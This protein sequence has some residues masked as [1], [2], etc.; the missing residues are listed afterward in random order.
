MEVLGRA[1]RGGGSA[2]DRLSDLPDCLLHA[3]LSRLKARQVVRTCV[4]S[5]RWQHLWLTSP[6]LDVDVGEFRE[7]RPHAT[8]SLHGLDP[9]W[10]L[11]P[12]EHANDGEEPYELP[13]FEDFVDSLLVHR[14]RTAGALPLE[15]LRLR[16]PPWWLIVPALPWMYHDGTFAA[17]NKH[18]RWVR[19]GL[20]CSPATLDVCG[21]VKLPPLSASTTRRL[22]SLRLDQVILH[23]DFAEHLASGLPVLEDLRITG[24]ILS[25]LP[26]IASGTL[27]SLVVESSTLHSG[28]LTFTIAAPRL[29]SLHLAVNFQHLVSFAVVVQEAPCLVQ[30]SVRLVGTPEPR[31]DLLRALCKFIDSLSHVCALKL[32]GFRDMTV[33]EQQHQPLPLGAQFLPDQ[34]GLLNP[35]VP[36]IPPLGLFYQ[37]QTDLPPL[38]TDKFPRPML[39]AMLDE[40][41]HGLPVFS[42]MRT[43]VLED[44]EMGDHAQTLWRFLHNAPALEKLTLNN[45]QCHEFPNSSMLEL[46]TVS[47]T[48]NLKSVGIIEG[49]RDGTDPEQRDES[50]TSMM[51]GKLPATTKIQVTK[52]GGRN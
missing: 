50:L 23:R 22:T 16:L 4:L 11:T 5:R 2:D 52:F 34:P 10:L 19:R 3:I 41:H 7:L 37:F 14:I 43:L 17:S 48:P 38:A 28:S 24:T 21:S 49:D 39:Q 27:K 47:L 30:A 12:A 15:T 45:C 46:P 32:H 6:C 51:L 35:H 13:D 36:F 1:K 25:A 20:Q 31:G 42:S 9:L 26:R 40:E 8:P 44:C 33:V 29:A 18:T